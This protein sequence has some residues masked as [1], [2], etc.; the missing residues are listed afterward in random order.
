MFT[1]R[2]LEWTSYS[3]IGELDEL[4]EFERGVGSILGLCWVIRI[5]SIFG[6]RSHFWIMSG[7]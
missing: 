1:G 3:H 7:V 2:T 5:A 4:Q 6:K